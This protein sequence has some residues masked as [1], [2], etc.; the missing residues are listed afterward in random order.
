MRAS[1]TKPSQQRKSFEKERKLYSLCASV[2]LQTDARSKVEFGQIEIFQADG[3]LYQILI[4]WD[5]VYHLT[6]SFDMCL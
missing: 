2:T 6:S 3:N 5:R 4:G 1:Q